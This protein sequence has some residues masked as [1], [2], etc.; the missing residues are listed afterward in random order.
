MNKDENDNKKIIKDNDVDSN[1]A[2][3][4]SFDDKK[5]HTSTSPM[6]QVKISNYTLQNPSFT[7]NHN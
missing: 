3:Q 4:Q 1:D 6:D 2:Y 7:D 5:N